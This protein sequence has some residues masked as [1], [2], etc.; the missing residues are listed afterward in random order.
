MKVALELQPCC[1]NRSGIGTYTYELARRL[2]DGDGLEFVGNVFNFLY[3]NDNT[4][5]LNDIEMPIR[6][7]P[8][9]PYGVYRRIWHAVP[10]SYNAMF[11]LA[12]LNVFFNFIVPP[13]VRGKVIT[14][15]YDMTYLRFP[16]TM[17]KSNLQR[18][19]RDIARCVEHSDKIITISEFSKR[20]IQTL[21]QVP[22][23]KIEIVYS[24]PSITTEVT[25]FQ[26]LQKRLN[27]KQPYLLYMGTIEPRKNLVRLIQAF[28]WLKRERKIPHQLVLAGGDGWKTEEIHRA[29]ETAQFANEIRFTGYLS[30]KEK[31]TLYQN[32]DLMAFPSLYEGFGMPPLEA[33]HFGCPVVCSNAASLPEV[34]GDAAELVDPF[35]P[36]SIAE[37]VMRVLSDREYAQSL[38]RRGFEQEKMFTWERSAEKLRQLCV[39]LLAEQNTG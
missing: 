10:V 23:E 22:E 21:L 37:G 24:A 6:V 3:R 14:V 15:I 29:A 31:N 2:Q 28:D 1:G 33:M 38:I 9:M 12:D 19:R 34:V 39:K 30:S 35:D 27:V 36:V 11:S 7:Q 8:C 25:S 20:E 32:A 13:R 16:E 5:A 4:S 26:M 18:I 17:N